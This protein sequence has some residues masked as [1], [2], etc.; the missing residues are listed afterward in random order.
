MDDDLNTAAA[1]AAIFDA[2]RDINSA[3]VGKNPTAET[4][5]L[6]AGVFDELTGVL[7][8]VYNRKKEVLDSDIDAMIEA[9]ANARKEKNWAEA[10]E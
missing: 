1:L 5:E 10:E 4:C 9:R 7:G 3:V 8:L 2:V 6:A